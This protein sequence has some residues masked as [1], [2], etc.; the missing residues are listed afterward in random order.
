MSAAWLRVPRPAPRDQQHRSPE[1]GRQVD[2]G[3]AGIA[4]A[5]Q[6]PAGAF[7]DDQIAVFEG[8]DR[9]RDLVH[10]DSGP[11][12]QGRGGG[13]GERFGVAGEFVDVVDAGQAPDL[14]H[15]TGLACG[16]AGLAGSTTAT[17]PPAAF[18]WLARAAVTMVL[19]TPVSV[20]A[21]TSSFTIRSRLSAWPRRGRRG[22]DHRLGDQGEVLVAGHVGGHRVDQVPEGPQP[23]TA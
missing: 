7:D 18:A 12:L 6:N 19:P 13:R 11:V 8:V 1:G 4:E 17:R 5:D 16:Y 20:P 3:L 2:Q 9:R 10:G 21:T 15:V 22:V 14:V 23:D